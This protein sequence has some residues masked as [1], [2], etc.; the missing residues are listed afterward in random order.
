MSNSCNEQAEI[1]R[2]KHAN[3][4]S[5]PWT[6]E[7]LDLVRDMRAKGFGTTEIARKIGVEKS[8]IQRKYHDLGIANPGAQKWPEE[9]EQK[10]TKMWNQG[11]TA[12][13]I[14]TVLSVSRSAVLRKAQ[15]LSLAK[16]K[17]TVQRRYTRKGVSEAQKN[18]V[19]RMWNGTASMQAIG[20]AIGIYG[21]RG[22]KRVCIELFGHEAVRERTIR[23]RAIVQSHGGQA[24]QRA[25]N[26]GGDWFS[27]PR[28]ILQP[29]PANVS[30]EG[31]PEWCHPVDVLEVTGCRY[32]FGGPGQYLFCNAPK[33]H[34][35][36][37]YCPHHM[38]MVYRPEYWREAA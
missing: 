12:R 19:R 23:L 38:R 31:I 24:F 14:A 10:L 26:R 32:T 25:Y 27:K 28:Q 2:K 21:H 9:L 35:K 16:R 37:S 6:Q 34:A 13:E 15:R 4:L 1:L 30:L 3:G 33:A 36:T 18:E 22:V 5:Y 29:V 8:T 7:E 20:V 11:L 17:G